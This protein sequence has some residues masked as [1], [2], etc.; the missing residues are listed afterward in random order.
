[1]F[2]RIFFYPL[3]PG[4]IPPPPQR[5]LHL[6]LINFS[7]TTFTNRFFWRGERGRERGER[8]ERGGERRERGKEEREGGE[9]GERGGVM[10]Q[11]AKNHGSCR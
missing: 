1:M 8:G 6:F 11:T 10:Q 7:H 9:R 5:R 3:N 2:L 4:F